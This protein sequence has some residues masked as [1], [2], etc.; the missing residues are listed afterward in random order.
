M[1]ALA[2]AHATISRHHS[3]GEIALVSMSAILFPVRAFSLFDSCQGHTDSIES[4]IVDG[5]YVL[6]GGCDGTVQVWNLSGLALEGESLLGVSILLVCMHT[7]VGL[8]GV[9]VG[10]IT[11]TCSLKVTG[12]A[13]SILENRPTGSVARRRRWR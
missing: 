1:V 2:A 8:P 13:G 10:L 7:H 3:V 9:R 12:L 11:L 4:L 6:S 5:L